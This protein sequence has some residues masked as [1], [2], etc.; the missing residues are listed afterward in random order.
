MTGSSGS[1]DRPH[2][3]SRIGYILSVAFQLLSSVD[4]LRCYGSITEWC[5]NVYLYVCTDNIQN[6]DIGTLGTCMGPSLCM[7]RY[8]GGSD[9]WVPEAPPKWSSGIDYPSAG[10]NHTFHASV[11]DHTLVVYSPDVEYG[12]IVTWGSSVIPVDALHTTLVLMHCVA[13]YR[14]HKLLPSMSASKHP[15]P[16][17]TRSGAVFRSEGS[18]LNPKDLLQIYV[19]LAV[20]ACVLCQFKVC[21]DVCWDSNTWIY[22]TVLWI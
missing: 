22:C 8:L 11:P 20:G 18:P 7:C 19:I 6:I 1:S 15:H 17:L 2:T 10:I 14:W 4:F 3:S 9:F 12:T 5:L 13:L 21:C 16:A